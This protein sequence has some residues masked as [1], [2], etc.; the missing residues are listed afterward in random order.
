MPAW[1]LI[2]QAD[3]NALSRGW[4]LLLLLTLTAVGL[5]AALALAVAIRRAR[6]LRAEA[7]ERHRTEATDAWAESAR[8]IQPDDPTDDPTDD[9]A[10]TTDDD[11]RA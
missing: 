8:R 4:T 6:R 9:P 1:H 7:R 5:V 10:E 11:L 3:P 2:A